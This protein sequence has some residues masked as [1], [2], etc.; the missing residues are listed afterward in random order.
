MTYEVDQILIAIRAIKS[1][2]ASIGSKRMCISRSCQAR[3]EKYLNDFFYRADRLNLKSL[4]H[5]WIKN[6]SRGIP[7]DSAHGGD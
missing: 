2:A 6:E 5:L 7:G 3:P 1:T 4:F